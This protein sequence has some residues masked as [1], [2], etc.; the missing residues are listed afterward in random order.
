MDDQSSKLTT[1]VAPAVDSIELLGVS[2]HNLQDIDVKIPHGSI[3][4]ITGPS[5]CG[6]SSLAFDTI[7]AESRRQF[8]DSLS[9]HAR[10][11]LR[12]LQRPE[13]RHSHGLLPAVCIDQ[14]PPVSN[15][16]ATVA[17]VSGV[18]DYLRLLWARIG[19]VRCSR[20]QRIINQTSSDAIEQ[21]ILTLPE[22]TK[23]MILAPTNN[24]DFSWEEQIAEIR[25]A[26]FLRAR[27]NDEVVDLDS[28][29]PVENDSRLEAVVDRIIVKPGILERVSESVAHALKFGNGTLTILSL[30]PESDQWNSQQASVLFACTDCGESY[31][32]V[33]PRTF[34]FFSPFG[35]CAECEGVGKLEQFSFDKIFQNAKGP[36]QDLDILR[37][38]PEDVQRRRLEELGTL[39]RELGFDL[40]TNIASL[41]DRSLNT[42]YSGTETALGLQT[43]LE[44]S[45]VTTTDNVLLQ[46]LLN[47]RA[48]E[49]CPAC[50][51][52]RL[53]T[54]ANHVFVNNRNIG[55]VVSDSVVDSI[56]LFENIDETLDEEQVQIANPIR[57]EIL[58]RLRFLDDIG[59][60]YLSLNRTTDTLSGGEFQRV[61]LATGLGNRLT[62]VCYVLDEPTTGLH[63]ADNERLIRNIRGIQAL[64]N[65]VILVEHDP[66]AMRIADHIVDLGPGAG[67]KGGKVLAQ[68][69]FESIVA[70]EHSITG[71]YLRGDRLVGRR[72]PRPLPPD[73]TWTEIVEPRLNNLRGDTFRFPPKLL[74]CVTG[75]SGSGKSS[76]VSGVLVHAIKYQE[77]S[78][79]WRKYCKSISNGDIYERVI[80]VDQQPIGRSPR[81]NAATFSGLFDELRKVFAATRMAKQLGFKTSHFSFNSRLGACPDCNGQGQIKTEMLF[82]PD[83]Y[84]VCE[85]CHGKRFN[86]S[87]LSIRFKGFSIAELLEKSVSELLELFSGFER[88][89]T[90][91]E[92][93]ERIGLGYLK[94]GQPAN[95]LSGGE[96]QRLKIAT[97]LANQTPNN[98]L[99]VLDE[100]TSGLHFADI[101][102]LQ[103][104]LNQLVDNGHTVVLIEHHLD[105]IRNADYV[106]DFGPG[107]G[108]QGGQIV[109]Q[110]TPESVAKN[111][112]SKTGQFLA[113]ATPE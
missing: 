14:K 83:V 51:G 80:F 87:T 79:A 74:T 92:S 17:T 105:M 101:E 12:N 58:D 49:P 35:V 47:F 72:A 9:I 50:R 27:I 56:R 54:A 108:S 24:E 100:P 20:C 36:I 6:K 8:L 86:Q 64:G 21:S 85:T 11:S 77:G 37:L 102:R 66:D 71:S 40:A 19:T 15:P 68:G 98:T 60:G 96:A 23:V 44:K 10:Q 88:I 94:L 76:M 30:E 63:P 53:C 75:V 28:L 65:T 41:D 112:H 16:R 2:T 97:H 90:F 69:N 73:A 32:E 25:K 38:L 33:E 78:D 106:I 93:L 61:R 31:D 48:M 4:V 99:F 22:R 109:A 103:D 89:R 13:I 1:P 62:D 111:P 29:P 5:G 104:V 95:S 59:V 70:S 42:I 45:Y 3:S 91:L 57:H 84:S 113:R 34:S 82:M 110:G 7:Y 26:G 52:S 46:E 55:Q 107:G 67:E 81:S 18:Y 39:L 43:I